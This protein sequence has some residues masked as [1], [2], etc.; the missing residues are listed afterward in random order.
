MVIYHKLHGIRIEENILVKDI[1]RVRKE[2]IDK[3]K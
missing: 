2:V 1:L 3:L